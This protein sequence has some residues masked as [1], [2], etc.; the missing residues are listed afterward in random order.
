VLEAVLD[1]VNLA[2]LGHSSELPEE[3]SALSETSGTEG[4][5]L[6]DEAATG[7]DYDTSSVS[8]FVVIDGGA[9]SSSGAKADSFVGAELVGGETIM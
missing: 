4:M 7:V 1:V 2:F 9:S 8:E 6:G 5:S 3:F